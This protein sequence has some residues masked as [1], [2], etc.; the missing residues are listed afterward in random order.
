MNPNA[1]S[2]GGVSAYPSIL[3]IPG[4]VDLA[5]IAVP[6]AQVPGVV[7]DCLAKGVRWT[8]R[9]QRRL[10]RGRAEGRTLQEQLLARVRDAGI[11]MIGPNCM[12]ILNT[13]PPS[14]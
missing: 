13:D 11:R 7:D 2:I 5:V 6:C 12:G 1:T 8:R 4:E 14:D 9:H 3:Q 10:W